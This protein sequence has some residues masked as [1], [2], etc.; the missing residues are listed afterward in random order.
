MS[1]SHTIIEPK[2]S[3]L[4]ERLTSTQRTSLTTPDGT[5]IEIA[6]RVYQKGSF[7]TIYCFALKI[8]GV[9]KG[10]FALKVRMEDK[11]SPRR[12]GTIYVLEEHNLLTLITEWSKEQPFQFEQD[13]EEYYH[14]L[15]SNKSH[16][17]AKLHFSMVIDGFRYNIMDFYPESLFQILNSWE[18]RE[19]KNR[20][21]FIKTVLLDIL[22]GLIDCH[23]GAN[24]AHRD[25]KLENILV[26]QDHFGRWSA[27]L[28]DFGLSAPRVL[29]I[30]NND[31]R[32]TIG[33]TFI[34]SSPELLANATLW[35]NHDE[36][37]TDGEPNPELVTLDL[38]KADVWATGIIAWQMV[39]N[40]YPFPSDKVKE[41]KRMI[42]NI[43]CLEEQ[44]EK[45][46]TFSPSLYEL[47]KRMLTSS[48]D[49]RPT[50][51]MLLGDP[52]FQ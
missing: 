29:T 14:Y 34:Y 51:R 18:R 28:T 42:N 9:F 38:A 52:F 32:G 47:V 40:D 45:L 31:D 33:G 6:Y 10:R 11:K 41:V 19:I 3:P 17:V 26:F 15:I 24:F 23:E 30:K 36:H 16:Y 48:P 35:V 39:L 21:V 20:E 49:E 4:V 37:S 43:E 12:S 27:R 5:F 2:S 46:K 22:C 50:A 7:S 25:I 1:A 8:G 13:S 44:W